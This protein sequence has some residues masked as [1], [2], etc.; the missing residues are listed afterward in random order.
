MLP[1][2]NEPT[3]QFDRGSIAGVLKAIDGL[4]EWSG[5]ITSIL[6]LA[7]TV[8]VC[9]ELI[10]RYVFNAP[11]TWGLEMTLYL[12]STTYVISGAYAT[13]YDAHI[14]VDIFY[15]RWTRRTR[16]F[17]DLVIT[18]FLFYFFTGVLVWQSALWFWE[19]YADK[20]TSGTIWD[21]P[22]WPMRLII[23]VGAVLLMLSGV[24]K[25]IREILIITGRERNQSTTADRG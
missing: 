1:T 19:A 20:L 6:I 24:A 23:F 5:K 2:M 3:N 14:R 17:F 9:Y 16:S 13:L 7:A 15:N 11:T 18:G 10:L 4:S 25:S 8:Q 21:P 12:C 22:I